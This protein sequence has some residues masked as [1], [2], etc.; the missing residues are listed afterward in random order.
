M[1]LR[2]QCGPFVLDRDV[3]MRIRRRG[4][5]SAARAIQSPVWPGA[6]AL[7]MVRRLNSKCLESIAA[8]AAKV[9]ESGATG[10]ASRHAGL[11]QQMTPDGCQRVAGCP[12]LLMELHFHDLP[13][14][15][16][17]VRQAPRPI[18]PVIPDTRIAIGN[19][20]ALVREIM[21]QACI[22]AHKSPEAARLSFGI[23]SPIVELIADLTG[24]EIELLAAEHAEELQLRWAD[25]T[26]FWKNLLEAALGDS[27]E[28]VG[29]VHMHCLQLLGSDE[30]P[31]HN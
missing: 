3:L 21:M 1:T 11:W 29:A 28:A 8:T 6:D 10:L 23:S 25:N 15:E 18:R 5:R 20:Q 12:V 17:V 9:D 30:T 31:A 14:W 4:R 26:T 19:A 22:I 13:W 24:S 2:G 27:E 16:W 7:K